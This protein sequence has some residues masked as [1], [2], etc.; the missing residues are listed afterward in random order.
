MQNSRAAEYPF[1]VG[2][3][4]RSAGCATDP[5]LP[6]GSNRKPTPETIGEAD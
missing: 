3:F 6:S 1:P 2:D 4:S 5:G